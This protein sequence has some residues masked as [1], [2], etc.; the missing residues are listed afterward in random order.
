MYRYILKEENKKAKKRQITEEIFKFGIYSF[1]KHY[2]TTRAVLEREKLLFLWLRNEENQYC[3]RIYSWLRFTEIVIIA[4]IV[5]INV[6]IL[7]I[8]R[9]GCV[10][11]NLD[12]KSISRVLNEKRY[13]LFSPD[14]SGLLSLF[15]EGSTRH[16]ADCCLV[17]SENS[18]SIVS[19]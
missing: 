9:N 3:I 8:R 13:R 7:M 12:E 4:E 1:S 15:Q 2:S 14:L 19:I 5:S 16:T 18:Q 6:P 11:M 17:R 10:L